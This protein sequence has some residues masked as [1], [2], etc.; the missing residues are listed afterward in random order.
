MDTSAVGVTRRQFFNRSLLGF[1]GLGLSGLVGALVAFIWPRP[2][3]A[4][5]GTI[6]AGDVG[7][8]LTTVAETRTPWYVPAGRFYVVPYPSSALASASLVYPPAVVRGMEQGVV[9]LYQKCPHLGCRVPFCPTSQWFECGCHQSKYNRVGERTGGPA[10]RGMDRFAAT[11][12]DGRLVVD[13]SF[14]VAGPPA[15][16]DTTGQQAEGP[17]CV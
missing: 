3:D 10:P 11:V 8:V 15:A 14:V 5:G 16:T 9:A 1:A 17:H 13:T 4:F 2:G 6:D 12:A 7:D